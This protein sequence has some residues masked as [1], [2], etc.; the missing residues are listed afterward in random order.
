MIP[1]LNLLPWRRQQRIRRA[2]WFLSS[3]AGV[4]LLSVT[5]VYVLTVPVMREIDVLTGAVATTRQELERLRGMPPPDVLLHKRDAELE[6]LRGLQALQ[7]DRGIVVQLLTLTLRE[8]PPG[9]VLTDIVHHAPNRVSYVGWTRRGD[10]LAEFLG[11]LRDWHR[12]DEVRLEGIGSDAAGRRR[13]E[14]SLDLT[15]GRDVAAAFASASPGEGDI[16]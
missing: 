11:R 3:L 5:L 12:T 14:V 13:F 9:I 6:R 7:S 1:R 2:R 8:V 10:A 16:Q 15:P 4:G